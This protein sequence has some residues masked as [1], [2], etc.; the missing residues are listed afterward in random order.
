M[1]KDPVKRKNQYEFIVNILA[2]GNQFPKAA[3]GQSVLHTYLIKEK[4]SWL[5]QKNW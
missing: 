5:N 4:T 3:P 1:L 2:A